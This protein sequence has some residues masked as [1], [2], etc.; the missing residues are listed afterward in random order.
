MAAV[1]SIIYR[2]LLAIDED[3]R[4]AA[5]NAASV[6]TLAENVTA[7]EPIVLDVSCDVDVPAQGVMHEQLGHFDETHR[8]QRGVPRAVTTVVD[9][10]P[11]R[12]FDAEV[13]VESSEDS[14]GWIVAFAEERDV[15]TILIGGVSSSPVGTALFRSVASQV[16]VNTDI[17]GSV[18]SVPK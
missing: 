1:P 13:H 15:D 3:E 10:L 17:P 5:D 14:A 4:Q 11:D 12:G 8:E 6:E 18:G 7:L 9:R 2:I 16:I